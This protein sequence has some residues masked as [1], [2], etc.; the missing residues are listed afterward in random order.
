MFASR[1]NNG[2]VMKCDDSC[3]PYVF[4]CYF[5]DVKIIMFT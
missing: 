3:S 4:T 1:R 5:F 2:D